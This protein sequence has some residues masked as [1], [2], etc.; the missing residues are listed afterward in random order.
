MNFN[1]NRPDNRN[2]IVLQSKIRTTL[3][4]VEMLDFNIPLGIIELS[5]SVAIPDEGTDSA[6]VYIH[7]RPRR[8]TRHGDGT[9]LHVPNRG[10][11]RGTSVNIDANQGETAWQTQ[12]P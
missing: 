2:Q 8:T 7:I 10:N 1:G 9:M 6:P 11:G 12:K 4:G 3:K 5:I